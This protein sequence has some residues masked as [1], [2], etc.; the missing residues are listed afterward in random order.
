[1]HLFSSSVRSRVPCSET[2]TISM[3]QATV[4]I[5]IYFHIVLCTYLP[6]NVNDFNK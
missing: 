4:Y 5:F 2:N 1:M 6:K 3:T